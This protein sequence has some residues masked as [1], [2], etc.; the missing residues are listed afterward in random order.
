MDEPVHIF[1]PRESG[2]DSHQKEIITLS[3]FNRL[4]KGVQFQFSRSGHVQKRYTHGNPIWVRNQ[5]QRSL[6][7]TLTVIDTKRA[8][9]FSAYPF[10]SV[11][12]QSPC[13]ATS[14]TRLVYNTQ[15]QQSHTQKSIIDLL[16]PALGPHLHTSPLKRSSP[17]PTRS[18]IAPT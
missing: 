13:K 16:H 15:N 14:T 17:K 12:C 5:F 11:L 18:L 7:S 4:Q 1:Q 8:T 10:P 3:R 2:G 9:M 6:H